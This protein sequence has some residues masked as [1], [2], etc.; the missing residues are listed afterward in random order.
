M[1]VQQQGTTVF[2]PTLIALAICLAS[3]HAAFAADVEPSS[4]PIELGATQV[5]GEG[6]LGETTEGTQSYTTGA[7]KTATKL[8]LTLRETPQAVTVVTRQRMDDQAMT[9]INDVVAATPGLFLNFSNGPG[10]QSYTARGFDIDNLMYDGIPSGY[11]GVNVGAQPNLA[12]FDRV[13]VVRGATGLVTGA[14]NP[15]A[16]INLIRKRPLDEQKVTLTGAAGTWDNYRGELDASSPLNDSGTWRG[17]V[18]TSYRDAN[19]FID[20]VGDYHGLFYAVTE[21]DLSENTSLTLGFS[22]QKDK[23]NYFWG[24][25]MVGQDGHHLNLS[26]A[27]NPGTR[28]ENKD[29]EINTVFAELRQQ[30]ANDWKLQVN[31]NYAEQNALFSGSYQSRW[32]NNT[33]A[34]TVYQSAADENQAGLDAFVSGPFQA[35][36]RSHELV[37]GASRRIYDLTTHSYSPFDMNWPLNAGK[38]DFVH[39][40]NG[41]EVTTQDGVYVTTRLSLADPLKLILGARLDWYDYDN[42][43]GDGD[44]KVTRNLTRYAGL[45]YDLDDHHSVYASYSDIFTPQTAKDTSGTPVRPIIG[46][47]YEVGIKGEYLGGALN[48]SVALFRVDQQN[49]AVDVV[50]PNCPQASCAEASGEIRSQGIDFELQ[51]ALTEHWQVGGGYTYARTHVIKDQANPQTVNKQFD[52]DTPEHLFKLTTRYNFQGPLE[53]LRVGG[54]ISWQSRMY[55]DLTVADGSSYRLKQGAYAVTD[56]MAGYQV[57]QHLDLQLNANNIFDRKYYETIANSVDYGG[58]SYGAPRNMMLTAKYSF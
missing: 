1:S 50:V 8:P 19:S 56:L 24:S 27:Y 38:P 29:Q 42:H 7:M 37:M 47:N 33:L 21:A 17:R 10:R 40:S 54:N 39:T 43:D 49:R 26:R 9:S 34:R 58:D 45:I 53:K 12:M 44:Y 31:A 16:A 6:Q 32:T 46:K 22:N 15:S 30:L 36:G 35:L 48:G 5:S 11:N 20:N 52:T 28:W 57:N 23:T 2:A 18:V 3:S 55:N 51:G 14:G 25:S 4:G 41:R 13:E